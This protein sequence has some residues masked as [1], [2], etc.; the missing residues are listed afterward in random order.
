MGAATNIT[1]A[2]TPRRDGY[3]ISDRMQARL[4]VDALNM[5]RHRGAMRAPHAG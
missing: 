2:D 4:A 1:R 3:S 5:G